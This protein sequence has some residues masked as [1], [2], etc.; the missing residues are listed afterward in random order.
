MFISTLTE[1]TRAVNEVALS[2]EQGKD[3]LEGLSFSPDSL[4]TT[5]R[6]LGIGMAGIFV[7]LIVIYIVSI[8]LQKVFPEK[9]K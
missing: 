3:I 6:Y 1:M 4:P 7:A 2:A 8:I 5:L 9:K